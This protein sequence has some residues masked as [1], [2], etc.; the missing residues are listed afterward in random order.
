MKYVNRQTLAWA[1]TLL[2]AAVGVA[3]FVWGRHHN[4]KIQAWF[5]ARPLKMA[6]DLS[7]PGDFTGTL[8]QACPRAC[9]RSF[10]HCLMKM[11]DRMKVMTQSTIRK[12]AE[13]ATLVYWKRSR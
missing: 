13:R 4:L 12:A 3:L 1:V 7:K 8:H 9:S 2:I 11:L 5:D 6:V 10:S